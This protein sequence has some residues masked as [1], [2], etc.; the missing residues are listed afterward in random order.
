VCDVLDSRF[1]GN[2]GQ[3]VIPD[4]LSVIPDCLSVIPG[5]D[6]GSMPPWIPVFTGMTTRA[7]HHHPVMPDHQ[8]VMPDLIGHP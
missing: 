4:C 3:L 1:R 5:H 6:R 2:D 8:P 7:A